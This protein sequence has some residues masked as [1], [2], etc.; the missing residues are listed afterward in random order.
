[1]KLVDEK[2]RLFGKINLIDLLVILLVLAVAF[3]GVRKLV[4]VVQDKQKES[5]ELATAK[6]ITYTVLVE[7][8]PLSMCEFAET[9]IGKN[10]INGYKKVD[11]VFSSVRYEKNLEHDWH[12]DLYI[13]LDGTATY[14]DYVYKVGTQECRIGYKIFVKTSEFEQSAMIVS[15]EVDDD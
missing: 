11:C 4:S 1:M 2:G 13:T 15:M 14:G 7:D 10:V 12:Y 9:Q 6:H 8:V 5:A 3:V